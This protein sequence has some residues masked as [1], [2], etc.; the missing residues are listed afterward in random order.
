MKVRG[1][2]PELVSVARVPPDKR[3]GGAG[4]QQAGFLAINWWSDFV[5]F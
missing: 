3:R 4:V 5:E 1:V 2:G